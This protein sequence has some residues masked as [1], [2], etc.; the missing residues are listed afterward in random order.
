METGTARVKCSP[1]QATQSPDERC[2]CTVDRRVDKKINYVIWM[3]IYQTPSAMT[4]LD[5]HGLTFICPAPKSH[6]FM[7]KP[8]SG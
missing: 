4:Y 1:R 5:D 3:S 2:A 8:V 6:H 7:I